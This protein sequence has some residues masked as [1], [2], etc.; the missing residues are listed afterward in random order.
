M[1]RAK[2]HA[3]A[4]AGRLDAA[5]PVLLALWRTGDD[6]ASRTDGVL[7]ASLRARAGRAD[8]ALALLAEAEKRGLPVEHLLDVASAIAANAPNPGPLAERLR[9]SAD[10]VRG[11]Q[12][13]TLLGTLLERAAQPQ[14]AIVYLK[15]AERE[16]PDDPLF[17][18]RLARLYSVTGDMPR[19]EAALRRLLTL[20]PADYAARVNLVRRLLADGREDEAVAAAR[21][22]EGLLPEADRQ[23]TAGDVL[24]R[25][26]LPRPALAAFD[27]ALAARP[28][29]CDALFG[30]HRAELGAGR[31][32]KGR[33][34]LW[35]LVEAPVEGAP[36]HVVESARLLL[37]RPADP[38]TG[39]R[40][41]SLVNGAGGADRSALRELLAAQGFL[42]RAARP[43]ARPGE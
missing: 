26:G 43:A 21:P 16:R 8:D 29:A 27:A 17:P 28:G 37:G 34:G 19:L 14:D 35:R 4:R 38:A 41:A 9:G 15:V 18:R 25:A 40:L 3:D 2:A 30:K 36:C 39:R 23:A 42:Q 13:A 24:L 22:P 7:L 10:A 12:R 32:A 11:P 31:R 1:R 33:R 5:D 20:D 6:P